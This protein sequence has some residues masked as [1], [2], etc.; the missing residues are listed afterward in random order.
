MTVGRYVAY[1][2]VSTERQGR[3]GG[4]DAQRQAVA[5]YLNGGT[6]QLL[7][8]FTEVESGK[9]NDRPQL[10]AALEACRRQKA[11]LVIA[12]LDRLARNVAFI[13]G[14]MESKVDFVAAD[15]PFANE[16]T[17]HI[18]AAVAQ[19]EHKQISERTKDALQAAK[20]RGQKLGWAIPGR[21]HEAR[22]ASSRGVAVRQQKAE[23]FAA[24]V[25]PIIRDIE[26]AGVTT[27]QGIAEALNARGV[28]TARGGKWYAATVRN[29]LLRQQ[30]DRQ[31][32]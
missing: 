12:K 27:L 32:A 24:N 29:L 13:S 4:L 30:H 16:F 3:S 17:I 8:E 18:M 31:A 1:Y 5:D 19:H 6:W 2:R 7:D 15:M 11:T 21:R 10:A 26:E 14:L 28:S 23:T 9:R 20:A 25:L 22:M